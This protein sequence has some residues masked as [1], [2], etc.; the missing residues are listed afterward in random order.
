V[1]DWV[2]EVIGDK[3]ILEDNKG[4]GIDK[5]SM[6][7]WKSLRCLV[8]MSGHD[9]QV[10]RGLT[11]GEATGM[12]RQRRKL[13]ANQVFSGFPP[14]ILSSQAQ[15]PGFGP[16]LWKKKKKDKITKRARLMAIRSCHICIPAYIPCILRAKC[17]PG[18]YDTHYNSFFS[19]FSNFSHVTPPTPPPPLID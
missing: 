15:G 13:E 19:S 5:A 2:A 17:N 4:L 14:C 16:R 7:S 1:Q 9:A 12:V 10:S 11:R 3:G 6:R 18:D 8:D